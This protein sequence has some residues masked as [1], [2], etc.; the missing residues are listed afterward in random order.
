MLAEGADAAVEIGL[1]GVFCAGHNPLVA[2]RDERSDAKSH[3]I[4]LVKGVG[5]AAD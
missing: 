1:A 3:Y 4:V 2:T 5:R